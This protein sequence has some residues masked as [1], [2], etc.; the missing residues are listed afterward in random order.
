MGLSMIFRNKALNRFHL[1]STCGKMPPILTPISTKS[2]SRSGMILRRLLSCL[3]ATSFHYLIAITPAKA[4]TDPA[5][6]VL[7][8]EGIAGDIDKHH[9]APILSVSTE[10][11]ADGARILVDTSV[12]DPVYAKYPVRVDFFVNRK[13]FSSQIR[14]PE[15]PGALGVDV[16]SALAALPF[17]YSV[18]ATLVQPNRTFTT[19]INGAAFANTLGKV[20]DCTLTLPGEVNSGDGVSSVEYLAESIPSSQTGPASIY[21]AFLG[22]SEEPPKQATA[23]VSLQLAAS[24]ATTERGVASAS[25]ENDG[26]TL[27]IALSGPITRQGEAI[28]KMDLTSASGNEKLS[29]LAAP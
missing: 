20:Y 2:P 23:R 8:A 21:F 17:N 27:N 6:L 22:V 14:S 18:V 15:L 12:P 4:Q 3:G 13:L 10:T 16:P 7:R 28:Q 9:R 5:P 29:C 24:T 11:T 1:F 19:V 25:V 26:K